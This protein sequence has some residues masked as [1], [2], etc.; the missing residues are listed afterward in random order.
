MIAHPFDAGSVFGEHLKRAAFAIVAP[1]EYGLRVVRAKA[2]DLG[3]GLNDDFAI[4]AS[5]GVPVGW[6]LAALGVAVLLIALTAA[7]MTLV[8]EPRPAA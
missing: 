1:G 4:R 5:E 8:R 7:L 2:P 6:W 3:P